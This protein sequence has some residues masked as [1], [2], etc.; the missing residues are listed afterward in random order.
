MNGGVIVESN[1]SSVLKQELITEH[2]AISAKR[3]SKDK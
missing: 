2:Y 1:S 3:P